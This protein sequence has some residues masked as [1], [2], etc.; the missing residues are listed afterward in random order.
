MLLGNLLFW[1]ANL[2]YCFEDIEKRVYFLFFNVTMMGFFLSRPTIDMIKG[3]VWWE[4]DSSHDFFAL[5]SIM[6]SSV[7]L[8]LGHCLFDKIQKID[9]KENENLKR[10]YFF[11][12]LKSKFIYNLRI[13]SSIL[14]YISFL[15]YFLL[16]IEKFLFLRNRDYAELY[17]AFK[18]KLPSLF[19]TI[20]SMCKYFMFIYLSTFPKKFS[21][22]IC[23]TLYIISSIPIFFVGARSFIVLNVIFSFL[24]YFTRDSIN[25]LIYI[26]NLGEKKWIGKPE[27]LFLVIISPFFAFIMGVWNYM[28]DGLKSGLNILETIVDLYYKQGVTY[29]VL[30]LGHELIPKFENHGFVNYTFGEIIDYFSHGKLAQILFGGRSLSDFTQSVEKALYANRLDHKLAYTYD[31]QWFISGHG[32]GSSYILEVYA[33]FGYIGIALFS[34]ILGA[35]FSYML[36]IMNKNSFC[37]YISLAFLSNVYFIPRASAL[38]SIHW[39]F[40][41]Q[42]I[43]PT[44]LCY[45]LA[46]LCVKEYSI[47]KV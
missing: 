46:R 15:F 11:E 8:F 14:F 22:F 29:H 28:R 9:S 24:Y 39:I 12:A 44:V 33:D 38:S 17:S 5:G 25:S 31:P 27:R 16:E 13:V 34:F 37:M 30:R 47:L 41:I 32:F 4:N 36:K 20:A 26:E 40:F 1:C 21:V 43:A 19:G 18:S 10:G 23:L 42:F 2:I 35:V 7:C 3:I 45:F 6:L